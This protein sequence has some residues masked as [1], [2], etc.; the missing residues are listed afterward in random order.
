MPN[1]LKKSVGSGPP[2]RSAK[3]LGRFLQNAGNQAV[4]GCRGSIE[5][6]GEFNR[7]EAKNQPGNFHANAESTQLADR[8]NSTMHLGRDICQSLSHLGSEDGELHLNQACGTDQRG[9]ATNGKKIAPNPK[10][11]AMLT[12]VG[13]KVVCSNSRWPV[14]WPGRI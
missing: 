7:Q 8:A 3:A 10:T 12:E 6:K 2:G 11:S 1:K 5:T 13:E 4:Q 14:P 9:D